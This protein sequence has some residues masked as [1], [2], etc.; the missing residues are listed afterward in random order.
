M[1]DRRGGFDCAFI[2]SPPRIVQSDCP[3]CL[4]VLRDPHQVT[5]CGY[6]YCKTCVERV[7]ADNK[8]CPCC[9]SDFNVFPNKGLQR[10]LSGFKVSCVNQ[11]EGCE[12]VG[13]LGRLESHLNFD[14][15]CDRLLEGCLWVKVH[16]SYCFELDVRSNMQTHQVKHCPLRPFTCEYCSEYQSHYEYV[17]DKHMPTCGSR[18]V[19]C[20]NQ[21]GQTVRMREVEGHILDVCPMTVVTVQVHRK[22][23]PHN[24]CLVPDQR[25]EDTDDQVSVLRREH[26]EYRKH[27]AS[28]TR[29]AAFG[30]ID[31]TVVNF[32]SLE[33]R[34]GVWKSSPFYSDIR[35][36]KF[37]VAIAANGATDADGRVY[38]SVSVHLMHGFFDGKLRWPFRG[39]LTIQLLDQSGS[40]HITDVLDFSCHQCVRACR[41]VPLWRYTSLY[42][43][44]KQYFVSRNELRPKYLRSDT[45][46]FQ[47]LKIELPQ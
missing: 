43:L 8:P 36:Y 30:P 17:V 46:H 16:C 42:G 1:A 13:E 35:G 28:L 32:S 7:R 44:R 23:L 14:P 25:V 38:V 33:M 11:K 10:A 5:C 2:E 6:S 40:D 26:S 34:N 21:C 15:V 29:V 39:R 3:L 24:H 9:K 22:D 20:P 27:V 31:V 45:L 37:L 12:W 18:P 41:R 4:L 19:Q 47:V